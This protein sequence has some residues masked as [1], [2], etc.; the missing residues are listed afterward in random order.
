GPLALCSTQMDGAQLA[1]RRAVLASAHQRTQKDQGIIAGPSHHGREKAALA[2]DR[3][4]RGDHL[5]TRL[6]R[7]P[8]SSG[9]RWGRGVDPGNYKVGAVSTIGSTSPKKI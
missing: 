2:S 9:E 5:A 7:P 4:W 8:G 3:L 6:W 1:R